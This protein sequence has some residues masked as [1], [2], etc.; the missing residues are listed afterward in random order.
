MLTERCTRSVVGLVAARMRTA[1]MAIANMTAMM[2]RA[3]DMTGSY[4]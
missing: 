1:A 3:S 2:T 4:S